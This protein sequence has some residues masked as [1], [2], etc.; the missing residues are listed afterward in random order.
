MKTSGLWLIVS[1]AA[2]VAHASTAAAD[3]VPTNQPVA[4][5]SQGAWTVNWWQTMVPLPADQNPSTDPD[6]SSAAAGDLGS[7]FMLA[8]TFSGTA[9]RTITV[10]SDQHHFVPLFG[11]VY[12]NS[13]GETE[14]EM[15]GWADEDMPFAVG[16]FADLNGTPLVA[17]LLTQ[18]IDSPPGLFDLTFN[19]DNIFRLPPGTYGC[20]ATGYW[21]MLE[22]LAIGT[23][24]LEFGGG[25]LGNPFVP[26]FLVNLTYTINVV[27]ASCEADVNADGLVNFFDL[28]A[29]LD[30]FNAGDPAADLASPPGV[31]NFFDLAAYLDLYNTGCP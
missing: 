3:V 16:L 11:L 8:G 26:D 15:R 31:L 29:Y 19:P 5:Q 20:V 17:D 27:P 28:A 24:T 13:E 9:S 21:L 6:G 23:H 1:A 18:R 12:I 7:V 2:L 4:G 14:A 30:L 10:Q 25:S 22:P